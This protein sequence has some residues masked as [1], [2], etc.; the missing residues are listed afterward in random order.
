MK[1]L[2]ERPFPADSL[3]IAGFV[4]DAKG[5]LAGVEV[6]LA[7]KGSGR[8]KTDAAGWYG[9]AGLRPGTYRVVPKAAGRKTDPETRTVELKDAEATGIDFT[10]R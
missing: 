10:A 6:R 4:R 7:G 9:F 3:S 5:P 2:E 1:V 8:T